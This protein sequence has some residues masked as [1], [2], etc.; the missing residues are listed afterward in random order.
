M[1][2]FWIGVLEVLAIL[3]ILGRIA[4]ALSGP[5]GFWAEILKLYPPI[6]GEMIGYDTE[7]LG[8]DLIVFFAIT[9][10]VRTFRERGEK[11]EETATQESTK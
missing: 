1:R 6:S 10:S 8:E 11:K 7:S 4:G 3:V 2:R 5:R 9:H